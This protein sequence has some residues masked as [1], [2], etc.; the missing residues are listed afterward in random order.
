MKP[1]TPQT[2]RL[3]IIVI[4]TLGSAF[5]L[6]AARAESSDVSLI[7]S[8]PDS[9]ACEARAD[10]LRKQGENLQIACD[11][12]PEATMCWAFDNKGDISAWNHDKSTTVNTAKGE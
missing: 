6:K 10:Q 11:C 9:A 8:Y 4:I 7:S 12:D 3:I 1:K 2:N 5:A